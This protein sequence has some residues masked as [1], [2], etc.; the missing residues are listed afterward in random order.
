[1]A[2]FSKLH[3][4]IHDA[5]VFAYAFDV[6]EL[7]GEDLRKVALLERKTLLKTALRNKGVGSRKITDRTGSS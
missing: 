2:D 6:M 4:R 5:E 3:S 1:V 7:G